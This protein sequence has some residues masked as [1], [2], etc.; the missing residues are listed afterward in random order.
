MFCRTVVVHIQVRI[1]MLFSH[2]HVLTQQPYT[3]PSHYRKTS[4][5]MINQMMQRLVKHIHKQN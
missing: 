4:Q 3:L 5:F 2:A 1:H